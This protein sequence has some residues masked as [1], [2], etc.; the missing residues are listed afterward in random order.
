MQ[1]MSDATTF[2]FSPN[3]W[4]LSITFLEF[5]QTRHDVIPWT[6]THL[7]LS[8][9]NTHHGVIFKVYN[10]NRDVKDCSLGA[11]LYDFV[12]E[13]LDLDYPGKNSSDRP[14]IVGSIN[15][16]IFLVI[17]VFHCVCRILKRDSWRD[18]DDFQG[19]K[20]WDNTAKF[21]DGKLP[22]LDKQWNIISIDLADEK[23][24]FEE[25][26]FLKQ[27]V[28]ESDLSMFRNYTW[29][30]VDVWVMKEYG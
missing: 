17:G 28:F 18:I 27:G 9:N 12:T 25:C 19:R 26:G 1:S 5:R 3:H 16:L 11:F 2:A 8:A 23:C 21:V 24:Y 15:G 14:W 20:L 13:A 29:I 30:H 7:L 22:W 10:A 6:K 4:P